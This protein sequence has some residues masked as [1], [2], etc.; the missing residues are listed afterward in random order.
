MNDA[1]G[2]PQ[3]ALVL[4]GGSDIAAA[5]VGRLGARGLQR[6]ILA[7]PNPDALRARQATA[8]LPVE[9][10]T[11]EAWDARDAPT[12]EQFVATMAAAHGDIDVVICAVGTLGHHS[13]IGTPSSAVDDS[14]RVNFSGPAAAIVA[15]AR[16]LV[17]QGHGTIVVLSSVAGERA[18]RSNF[19]YGSAKAGLDAFAQG[20]TDALVGTGVSLHVIRPGFVRSK[21]T[22]GL[23]EAPFTTDAG[24]VADAV[25]AAL[26]SG[27][28]S[29]RWVPAKLRVVFFGLRHLPRPLWRRVAADR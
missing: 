28:S 11:I 1:F 15:A 22:A 16:R 19:V 5:I 21:M 13:G 3:T 14:I 2:M 12:H 24:A 9:H 25:V 8:P 17:E 27:R 29:T 18:R 7:T 4:G 20:L 6:V 23:P 10:V 26:A